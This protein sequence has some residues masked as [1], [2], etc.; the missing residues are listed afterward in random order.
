MMIL[1]ETQILIKLIFLAIVIAASFQL[2]YWVALYISQF[3][4]VKKYRVK[5]LEYKLWN[6]VLRAEKQG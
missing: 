3:K 1:M 4:M 2:V 6:K 5:K